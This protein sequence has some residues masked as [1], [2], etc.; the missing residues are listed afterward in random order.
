MTDEEAEALDE[1]YTENTIMPI[2]PNGSG[3]WSKWRKKNNVAHIVAVDD[4]SAK[5]LESKAFATHKTP[6]EIVQD[7]IRK[8]IATS[9]A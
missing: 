3:A 5:Y 9:L 1:Y 6:S 7:L 2:G 4:F 8:E